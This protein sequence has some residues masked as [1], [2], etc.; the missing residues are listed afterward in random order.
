MG[1][2]SRGLSLLGLVM[3]LSSCKQHQ[4]GFDPKQCWSLTKLRVQLGKGVYDLPPAHN[5]SVLELAVNGKNLDDTTDKG[6]PRPLV[7]IPYEFSA[8]QPNPTNVVRS[9]QPPNLVPLKV[10]RVHISWNLDN[11]E[12]QRSPWKPRPLYKG[13]PYIK[14]FASAHTDHPDYIK[15]PIRLFVDD[16]SLKSIRSLL[17]PTCDKLSDNL[18]DRD[19][20]SKIDK[21]TIECKICI[22]YNNDIDIDIYFDGYLIFENHRDRAHDAPGYYDDGTGY[23]RV[24]LTPDKLQNVWRSAVKAFLRMK[25]TPVTGVVK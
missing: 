20:S 1:R 3:L 22:N 18:V 16:V 5:F 6:D 21:S 14:F 10:S 19:K 2:V 15:K 9:C 24:P 12:T 13:A 11:P 8:K 7:R 17:N 4:V 25:Y 23:Y